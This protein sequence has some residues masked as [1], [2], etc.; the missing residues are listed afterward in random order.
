IRQR[1]LS[2]ISYLQRLATKNET[3]SS[4]GPCAWG[5]FD[6]S[7]PAAASIQLSDQR[8]SRRTVYI[9]RWVC[10]SLAYLLSSDR[11][12]QPLLR[13]RLPDDLVIEEDCATW[14]G[15]GETISISIAEKQ[16]LESC[17]VS[18]QRSLD[19]SLAEELVEE[20]LLVRKLEVAAMPLPFRALQREV[21]DW[22][23]HPA[24]ERWQRNL[25]EIE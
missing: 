13:L 5:D 1:E 2:W 20:G 17:D 18:V 23:A 19:S 8:I 16:F 25:D 10:E 4:Y 9:E 14:L 6:P 22:P 24:R 12:I 11:E 15:S 7:E 3:I 21:A